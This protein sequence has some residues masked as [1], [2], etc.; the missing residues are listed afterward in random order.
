MT[1]MKNKDILN[2]DLYF[3]VLLYM[4]QQKAYYSVHLNK[5]NYGV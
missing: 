5:I 2:K 1:L 3:Y 4:L